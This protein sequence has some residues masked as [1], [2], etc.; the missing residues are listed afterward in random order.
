MSVFCD[1]QAAASSPHQPLPLDPVP[2]TLQELIQQKERWSPTPRSYFN[3]HYNRNASHSPSPSPAKRRRVGKET[4]QYDTRP[5]SQEVFREAS[6]FDGRREDQAVN[7]GL[8]E[9]VTAI[10]F[11]NPESSRQD[12][13]DG[14]AGTEPEQST[15]VETGRDGTRTTT[16]TGDWLSNETTGMFVDDLNLSVPAIEGA[17][18]STSESLHLFQ[19]ALVDQYNVEPKVIKKDIVASAIP[20]H[21]P[22]RRQAVPLSPKQINVPETRTSRSLLHEPSLDNNHRAQGEENANAHDL[23]TTRTLHKALPAATKPKGS[24]VPDVFCSPMDTHAGTKSTIASSTRKLQKTV[25]AHTVKATFVKPALPAPGGL[26]GPV[27]ALDAIIQ[28]QN[29]QSSSKKGPN[30][31]TA[32]RSVFYDV[33]SEDARSLKRGASTSLMDTALSAAEDREGILSARKK[34]RVD[35]SV[36]AAD[37]ITEKG[38]EERRKER[39]KQDSTATSKHQAQKASERVQLDDYKRS[40]TKAFPSFI[41]LF[42]IDADKAQVRELKEKIKRLG[43]VSDSA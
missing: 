27:H 41:F 37:Y 6:H 4:N 30:A 11:G 16:T 31:L 14:T 8:D 13:E 1:A 35:G 25:S 12:R 36:T 24:A 28:T 34:R 20:P 18:S 22:T 42:E 40:Y 2:K 21:V 29:L 39:V 15:S 23:S 3:D 17:N 19:P 33:P 43:G 10:S 26:R 5:V 38:G 9:E 7:W 32:K